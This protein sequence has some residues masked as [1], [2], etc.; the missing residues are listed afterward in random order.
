MRYVAYSNMPQGRAKVKIDVGDNTD[1]LL[2]DDIHKIQRYV[3]K[4]LDYH[5]EVSHL[6]PKTLLSYFDAVK[7]FYKSNRMALPGIAKT[8]WILIMY[9][10]TSICPIHTRRFIKCWTRQEK[11][12][13]VLF[14]CY[15]AAE[16]G[17]AQFGTKTW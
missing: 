10:Q 8:T 3:K 14:F 5:Y 4:F 13:D 2:F 11:W 16:S 17:S 6:S 9:L 12:N 15:A 7:Q 1:L